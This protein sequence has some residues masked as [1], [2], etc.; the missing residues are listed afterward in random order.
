MGYQLTTEE[1][2]IIIEECINL[3]RIFPAMFNIL[4]LFF[5]LFFANLILTIYMT[6]PVI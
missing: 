1:Q 4:I 5:F 2:E 6:L 3:S